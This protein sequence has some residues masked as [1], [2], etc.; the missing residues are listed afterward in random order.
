[1]RFFLD[2]QGVFP[3]VDHL[4][5]LVRLC[6]VNFPE[7]PI[8]RRGHEWILDLYEVP[9]PD[10]AEIVANRIFPSRGRRPEVRVMLAKKLSETD[11]LPVG[12]LLSARAIRTEYGHAGLVNMTS[13]GLGISLGGAKLSAVDCAGLTT[14]RMLA[15]P[16]LAR[17]FL[18]QTLICD[19]VRFS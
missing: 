16:A 18:N 17:L 12:L 9:V 6:R 1:M 3:L 5:Q 2:G 13:C 14:W 7:A 4:L 10:D 15:L 11:M 19:S 8:L